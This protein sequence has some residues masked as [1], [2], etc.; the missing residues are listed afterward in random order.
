M[1]QVETGGTSVYT[2]SFTQVASD[3]NGIYSIQIAGA[4][5]QSVLEA[6]NELWLELIINQQTLSPRQKINSVPYA[7]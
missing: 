4:S 1:Y 2:E 6:N 5:L 7:L 3:A